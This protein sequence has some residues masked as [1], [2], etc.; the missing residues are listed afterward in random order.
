[1]IYLAGPFTHPNQ[2]VEHARLELFEDAWV[3]MTLVGEHIYCP[4]LETTK[5]AKRRKLPTDAEWWRARNYH[6]FQRCDAMRILTAPGWEMSE[7]LM[8][9]REWADVRRV[10]VEYYSPCHLESFKH[11]EKELMV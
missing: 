9:E 1:M 6:F 4:I 11:F 2:A 8:E 3:E 7:G 5:I 10:L